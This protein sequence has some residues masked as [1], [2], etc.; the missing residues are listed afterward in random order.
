MQ[1]LLL[2]IGCYFTQN[3][4][5]Q[6]KSSAPLLNFSSDYSLYAKLSGIFRAKKFFTLPTK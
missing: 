4:L 1:G 3:I 2:D 6:F 5:L